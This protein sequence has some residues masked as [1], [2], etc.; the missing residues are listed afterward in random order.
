[1]PGLY[2]V[3]LTF[4][5]K[6]LLR[7]CLAAI[8]EQTLAPDA[9]IVIDNGSS[10]GTSD[11]LAAEFP[12]VET[13]RVRK[14]VGAAGGFNLAMRLAVAGGAD[15]VWVMDDDVIAEPEALAHLV[16]ALKTAEQH[17]DEP[18]FVLSTARAPNGELT[19]VP[20]IDR[21]LNRIFYGKW[22][23]LL[24]HGLVPVTRATFVSILLPARTFRKH[25]FP[26]GSMFIW[27]EDT[28]FTLRITKQSPGYLC[29]A[30]KVAHIRAQPGKL[31]IRS[32]RD[33]DRMLW[34]ECLARNTVYAMRRHR[35]RRKL[36]RY[37]RSTTR[38]ILRLALSGD[39]QRAG[40]LAR[41][42]A[43]G[44][45]FTP[46]EGRFDDAIQEGGIAF[47]APTLFARITATSVEAN[48]F[49]APAENVVR[50]RLEMRS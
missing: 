33:F 27:G 9:V 19:N 14:N 45:F 43:K 11:M 36:V 2:A 20:E 15:H 48:V 16:A 41:G 28:E 17:A 40:I 31:D 39:F 8:A 26:I 30:S 22:P 10:D 34:H 44:F 25:G 49:G 46:N 24:E 13:C 37:V 3:V 32:E 18:P 38:T 29:G 12:H 6:A 4:N 1:M 35:S 5:R 23:E 21:S 47:I 7:Q 42:L 50:L